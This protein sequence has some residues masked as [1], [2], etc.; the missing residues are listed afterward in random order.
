M[1]YTPQSLSQSGFKHKASHP[2]N[3]HWLSGTL[4]DALVIDI[5]VSSLGRTT[6]PKFNPTGVRTHDLWITNSTFHAP[7][8][9]A[10]DD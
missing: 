6:H 4:T 8:G 1:D 3:M 5:F 2:V 10:L 7:Y 9:N